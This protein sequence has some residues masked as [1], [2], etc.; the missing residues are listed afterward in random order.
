MNV[1]QAKTGDRSKNLVSCYKTL[2]Q[3]KRNDG[4][5]SKI[6][7][8]RGKNESRNAKK[9]DTFKYPSFFTEIMSHLHLSRLLSQRRKGVPKDSYDK[10]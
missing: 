10:R 2:L 3:R 1:M 6:T 4:F 9:M 5:C 8:H 7:F